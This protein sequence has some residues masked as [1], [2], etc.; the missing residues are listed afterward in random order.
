M[1]R[2]GHLNSGYHGAYREN[3]CPFRRQYLCISGTFHQRWCEG[4]HR[5]VHQKT[6]KGS[7]CHRSDQ[8]SVHRNGRSGI[9]DRGKPSFL[10]NSTI[11]QQGNGYSNRWPGYQ[12]DYRKYHPW[13]WLWAGTS[14]GCGLYCN[15]DAGVLLREASWSWNFSRTWDEIYR[16]MSWYCK[17]L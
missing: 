10:K 13:T 9:C 17:D 1:R 8:H 4:Y 5:W 6:C 11:H 2:W 16:R 12:G 15:Q 3:R 14:S 7:S